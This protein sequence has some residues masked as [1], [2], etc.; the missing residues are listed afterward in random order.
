M[1][2][3][4][5]RSPVRRRVLLGVLGALIVVGAAV[6]L[7]RTRPDPLPPDAERP[8]AEQFDSRSWLGSVEFADAQHGYALRGNCFEDV[9]SPCPIELMVTEDGEHW[10]AREAPVRKAN[11]RPTAIDRLWVLGSQEVVVGESYPTPGLQ[12]W[13]S[14]DGGLTWRA[15]PSVV[16]GSVPDVPPGGVLD[17]VCPQPLT[18]AFQCA[19]ATPV[20]TLP[21]TGE[22]AELTGRPPLELK[23]P[24]RVPA[25]ADGNLWMSGLVPGTGRWAVAV[26]ADAGRTWSV[27]E[28]PDQGQLPVTS[29]EVS[30][31][32]DTVFAIAR[33]EIGTLR[34]IYASTDGGR[35]WRLTRRSGD[36]RQPVT[37]AGEAIATADGLLIINTTPDAAF[38]SRDQGTS[39]QPAVTPGIARWTRTG[40]VVGPAGSPEVFRMSWNGLDWRKLTITGS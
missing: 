40:Y 1:T 37:I 34:A 11:G 7:L 24:R 22:L 12:R 17:V 9:R 18:E 4:Q 19:A 26:S 27:A 28:L 38:S 36:G 15:V 31:G 6:P 13:Y 30:V 5:S 20:V 23:N 29:V 39:F 14:G 32:G 25:T 35:S 3:P 33:H 8:T 21:G 2:E 16:R 10:R